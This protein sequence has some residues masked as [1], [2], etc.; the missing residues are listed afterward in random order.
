MTATTP[1]SAHAME[2]ASRDAV[3]GDVTKD[4]AGN[5]LEHVA[6]WWPRWMADST[7]LVMESTMTFMEG[8]GWAIFYLR[9]RRLREGFRRT[10]SPVFPYPNSLSWLEQ[11]A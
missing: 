10:P 1:S 8:T 5:A 6:A 11:S 9:K 2:A 3:V 4:T 7:A